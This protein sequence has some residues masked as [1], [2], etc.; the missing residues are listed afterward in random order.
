MNFEARLLMVN[1]L[2]KYNIKSDVLDRYRDSNR[3]YH[4]LEHLEYMVDKAREWGIISDELLL[5]IIFHDIVYDPKSNNNE[6]RSAYVA[7]S[8]TFN[9]TIRDA[10]LDTKTHEHFSSQLSSDLCKLDIHNLYADFQTFYDNSYKIFK[11]YQFVDYKEFASKR[12]EVLKHYHVNETYIEAIKAFKPN[13]GVYA[14]SFN[15]FHKGHLNILEKA[16]K[17]FDKV[18]IARGQNPTKKNQPYYTMPV[19]IQNRQVVEYEGLL[20]DFI[21]SLGYDV[22]LIRGL[23]NSTDLQY[24]M[25]QYQY[26]RDFKPDIK[27]VS[28]FCDKEFEHISSSA[29]QMLSDFNRSSN[30]LL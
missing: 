8:L 23:R 2:E 26:C 25:T 19:Q 17:I 9:E 27:V 18:I 12:I 14:G 3:F 24:E 5:A 21:N 30:Y 20:T 1:V 15:P 6:E 7:Y 11:E 28:I 16:E 13:I 4:N 29:I 10:I 22:T